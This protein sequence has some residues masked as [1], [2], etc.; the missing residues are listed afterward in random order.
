VILKQ[1]SRQLSWPTLGIS[2]LVETHTTVT[3]RKEENNP[4]PSSFSPNDCSGT[5]IF[6][7]C[8]IP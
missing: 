5:G 8:D 2:G 7:D 1:H 3:P 4:S 6:G